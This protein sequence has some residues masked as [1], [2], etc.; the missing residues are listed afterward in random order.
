MAP[1]VEASS[2][3]REPLPPLVVVIG[4]G[5]SGLPTVKSCLE[6][7]L[8]VV[9]L[10]RTGG[11]GGLWRYT[12]GTRGRVRQRGSQHDAQQLQGVFGLQRLP[13]ARRLPQFHAPLRHAGIPHAIQQALR[14]GLAHP[15]QPRRGV[16]EENVGR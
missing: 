9:C 3:H 7:G 16:R 8:R 6:E 4:A 10:E 14:L 2:G 1:S 5:S 13:A 11:V 12:E 15:F